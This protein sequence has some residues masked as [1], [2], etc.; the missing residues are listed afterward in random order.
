M[1]IFLISAY[2]ASQ[3][4]VIPGLSTL[5]NAGSVLSDPQDSQDWADYLVKVS[6]T[7][8]AG[9]TAG[10]TVTVAVRGSIDNT[11][12]DDANNERPIGAIV[13]PASGAQTCSATFAVAGPTPLPPYWVLSFKNGSGATLANASVTCRG[14]R[15]QSIRTLG[16]F[17]PGFSTGFF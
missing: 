16:A 11:D 8:A 7:S 17:S 15:K 12:Y 3:S 13:F 4:L 9:A 1:A 6:V 2:Q 14:V 10:G 5:V